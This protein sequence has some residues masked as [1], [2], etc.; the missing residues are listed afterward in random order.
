MDAAAP[1]DKHQE[2]LWVL[3]AQQRDPEAFRCLVDAYEERLLYFIR[4]FVKDIDDALDVLQDVWLTMFRRLPHLHAPAAF[5]VWL[6]QV[7]HD[8]AVSLIR[9]QRRETQ[10]VEALGDSLDAEP[11]G[12]GTVFEDAELVHR[13]LQTLS[14]EH[15]EVLTL[16]F[17]EDLRLEE[18]AEILRCPIGTVKSRLHYAKKCLRQDMEKRAYG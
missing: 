11:A 17:L 12:D 16:H 10:A 4:R 5:R 2:L 1:L 7:A 6:Y 18:I 8:K 9:D 13:G 3:R 14:P 15:R